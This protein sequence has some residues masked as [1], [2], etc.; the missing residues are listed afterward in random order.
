MSFLQRLLAIFA[1]TRR[2]RRPRSRPTQRQSTSET[3]TTPSLQAPGPAES[4]A[5]TAVSNTSM[6]REVGTVT[7]TGGNFTMIVNLIG[8]G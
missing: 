7:I 8:K 4:V 5:P 6:F 1:L 2:H 3:T